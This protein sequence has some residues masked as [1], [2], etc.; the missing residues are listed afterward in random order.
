MTAWEE[1]TTNCLAGTD[2]MGV[3]EGLKRALEG[4][5]ISQEIPA[6]R[7]LLEASVW[8]WAASRLKVVQPDS[9]DLPDKASVIVTE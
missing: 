6:H 5:P 2:R 3:S 1:L 4:V 8:L 7:F 9:P